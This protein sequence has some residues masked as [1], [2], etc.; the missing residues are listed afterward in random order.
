[1]GSGE[2]HRCSQRRGAS[3]HVGEAAVQRAP[4]GATLSPPSDGTRVR[5]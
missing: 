2:P 5:V 4:G 3:R 1:M